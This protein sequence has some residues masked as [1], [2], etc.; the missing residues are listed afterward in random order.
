M[1]ES[2]KGFNNWKIKGKYTQD[3]FIEEIK[4]RYVETGI[5]PTQRSFN[6]HASYYLFGSWTDAIIMAGLE[7]V[8][9]KGDT[10]IVRQYVIHE[11]QQIA[12]KNKKI[13]TRMDYPRWAKAI[14]LFGSWD[15]VLTEAKIENR[16]FVDGKQID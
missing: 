15:K 2:T 12:I 5:I 8:Q 16:L 4:K 3:T 14:K 9:L 6:T 11:I 7:P 10:P 13:P 1:P